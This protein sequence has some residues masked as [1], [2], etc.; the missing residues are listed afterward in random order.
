MQEQQAVWCWQHLSQGDDK[1]YQCKP[2]RRQEDNPR[3]NP[4]RAEASSSPCQCCGF[5]DKCHGWRDPLP[6]CLTLSRGCGSCQVQAGVSQRQWPWCAWWK[7]PAWSGTRQGDTWI[8]EDG[9]TGTCLACSPG[10]TVFYT[11]RPME[12]CIL[13]KPMGAWAWHKLDHRSSMI[14][15]RVTECVTLAVCPQGHVTAPGTSQHA[16]WVRP[17]RP[18]PRMSPPLRP[19]SEGCGGARSGGC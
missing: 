19:G 5:T 14:G 11:H 3:D 1:S 7:E 4:A 2:I 15:K 13:H 10:P 12:P 16:S 9:G 6:S 18:S 17:V 8:D